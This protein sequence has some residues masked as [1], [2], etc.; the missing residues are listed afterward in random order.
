MKK[1]DGVSIENIVCM[2]SYA[3]DDSVY[4]DFD[5]GGIDKCNR[6]DDVLGRLLLNH[7]NKVYNLNREYNHNKLYSNKPSGRIDVYKSISTG[8]Y[9]DNKLYYTKSFYTEDV[10]ENRIIKTALYLLLKHTTS[11]NI[12]TELT[13]KIVRLSDI[14]LIDINKNID[15]EYVL[16]KV[17]TGSIYNKDY[18]VSILLSYFIL[19]E[20]LSI[21]DEYNQ[22]V[23]NLADSNR[24]KYIFER[25]VRNY[26]KL[27][28]TEF[29][30]THRSYKSRGKNQKKMTPDMVLNKGNFYCV[31]DAKWYTLT[32]ETTANVYQVTTYG[33]AI[34]SHYKDVDKVICVVLYS[35]NHKLGI[36]N[37]YSKL[38]ASDKT[39]V[40]EVSLNMNKQFI[41]IKKDLDSL[42]DTVLTL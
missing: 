38:S 41:D 23:F 42:L 22:R 40:I 14:S 5:T 2:L 19:N 25:F 27:E 6:L 20:Y 4:T 1:V 35:N 13:S 28:H 30:V 39:Y 7:L 33:E 12:Q 3:L 36:N 37:N 34:L 16:E 11:D 31:I 29:R 26:Y 9:F 15:I 24:L 18:K 10:I 8:K 17:E 32:S 21:S